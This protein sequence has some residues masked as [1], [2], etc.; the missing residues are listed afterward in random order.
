ML[1]GSPISSDSAKPLISMKS[2]F[3]NVIL[4]LR[5][6]FDTINVS[7]ARTTSL[8]V[9]GKLLLIVISSLT[10]VAILAA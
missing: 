2:R 4:P 3:T 5:S 10:R 1:W 8:S 9:T 7:G 6:V